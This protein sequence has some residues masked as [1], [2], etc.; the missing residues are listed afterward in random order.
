[1][2]SHAD[3]PVAINVVCSPHSGAVDRKRLGSWM[4]I[5]KK[6]THACALNPRSYRA[7]EWISGVSKFGG[8]V[9]WTLTKSSTCRKYGQSFRPSAG[10]TRRPLTFGAWTGTIGKPTVWKEW[11]WRR[12]GF[13]CILLS[14]ISCHRFWSRRLWFDCSCPLW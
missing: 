1:M 8:T 5:C 12:R 7:A 11:D 10:R 6:C 13:V 14:C 2:F 9:R 4:I 3:V